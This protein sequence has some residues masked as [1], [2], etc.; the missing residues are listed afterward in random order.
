LLSILLIVQAQ[1]WPRVLDLPELLESVREV[2]A[3]LSK[4]AR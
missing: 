3:L 4:A 1:A 2:A